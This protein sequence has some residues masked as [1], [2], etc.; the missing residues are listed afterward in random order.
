MRKSN[1]RGLGS[2]IG[3]GRK[4][5]RSRGKCQYRCEVENGSFCT[6]F[7]KCLNGCTVGK[8]HRSQI[9]AQGVFPSF[10]GHFMERTIAQ[11]S[12]TAPRHMIQALKSAKLMLTAFDRRHRHMFFHRIS[13][14]CPNGFAQYLPRLITTFMILANHYDLCSGIYAG[15]CCG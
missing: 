11:A 5:L 12:P 3:M 4:M 10:D 13:H 9:Q 8:H 15:L 7:E 2:G 14:S 1:N 6:G